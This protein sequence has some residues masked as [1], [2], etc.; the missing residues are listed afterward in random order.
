[1]RREDHGTELDSVAGPVDGL[2]R[3]D[4]DGV[5]FVLVLE[6]GGLQEGDGS[7]ALGLKPVVPVVQLPNTK[8]DQL[9]L[10]RRNSG[11]LSDLN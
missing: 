1:M 2:V 10:P 9:S 7:E 6:L 5:A 11:G 4:E 3:L 8:A